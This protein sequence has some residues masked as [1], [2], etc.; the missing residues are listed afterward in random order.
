MKPVRN[1]KQHTV[2]LKFLFKIITGYLKLE[3]E[4]LIQGYITAKRKCMP[5]K[6]IVHTLKT[7][8]WIQHLIL[9]M[10]YL[11]PVLLFFV[12]NMI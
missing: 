3:F 6:K 8:K 1:S 5:I 7:E 12:L 4:K 11:F 9:A 10:P 2:N